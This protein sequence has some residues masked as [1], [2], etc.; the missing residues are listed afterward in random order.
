MD[1]VDKFMVEYHDMEEKTHSALVGYTRM[2]IVKCN[3]VFSRYN[4]HKLNLLEKWSLLEWLNQHRLNH[5]GVQNIV[6]LMVNC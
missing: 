3:L 1:G 2:D 6:P 5:F 4:K